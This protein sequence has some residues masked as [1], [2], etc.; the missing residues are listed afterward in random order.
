MGQHT[1]YN[2]VKNLVVPSSLQAVALYVP[3]SPQR[4]YTH[5]ILHLVH[6]LGIGGTWR[7][8]PDYRDWVPI[9]KCILWVV[10]S[11][12]LD[13]IEL[14]VCPPTSAIPKISWSSQSG[15]VNC[16]PLPCWQPGGTRH[17]WI[18]LV[19]VAVERVVNH[20]VGLGALP[21]LQLISRSQ[22]SSLLK[23]M[24]AWEVDSMA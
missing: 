24:A 21:E 18:G 20:Q 6:G 7:S 5:F 1:D 12:S 17:P 14:P 8:A 11:I 2:I 22:S 9:R 16:T 13:P 3:C 19:R 10:D 4:G 15:S 23:K